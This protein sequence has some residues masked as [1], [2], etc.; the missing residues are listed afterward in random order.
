M[1]SNEF[2]RLFGRLALKLEVVSAD[3]LR[4]AED[5]V[6]KRDGTELAAV[7]VEQGAMTIEQHDHVRAK[8]EALVARH[9]GDL[10]AALTSLDSDDDPTGTDAG[11]K[12][13]E[14]TVDTKPPE[15]GTAPRDRAD[16][17]TACFE[18]TIITPG[19]GDGIE[20]EV[21]AHLAETVDRD[22]GGAFGATFI[23]PVDPNFSERLD[24]RD[25]ES[26]LRSRYTLTRVC[27]VGGI[28]EVWLAKDPSLKRDV[29]LKRFRADREVDED[30]KRR[31]V[32][33][34]QITGQLEHPNIVPVH[35]LD[36]ME[37]GSPYYTMKLLR[38]QTLSQHIQE[39]HKLKRDGQ[40]SMLSLYELLNIFV[41]VCNAVA[42][43]GAR[44]I[45]HRDLKPANIM[46]GG[47]G[48]VLVLDWG[49]A[50]LVDRSETDEEMEPVT[51]Q[52]NLD[53]VQ[54][55]EGQIVGTP[56]YMAPEQAAGR[57]GQIDQRTDVYGLGAVLYAILLGKTPHRGQQTG[58][59]ARDTI[60]LLKRIVDGPTPRPRTV[61]PTI[62][63][64]LDA[65]SAKAME[66]SRSDRYQTAT[67]IAQDIK[68]WM[69][70]EP[71]SAYTEPWTD[72][73]Q[74]WFRKHRTLAQSIVIGVVLT[75]VVSIFAAFM[76]N[77]A[78]K[79]EANAHAETAAARLVALDHFQRT[80][81][82][83]DELLTGLSDGLLN[84]PETQDF[85]EELLAYAEE[86]YAKLVAETS[87]DAALQYEL[88]QVYIRLGDVRRLLNDDSAEES[89]LEAI[90]RL[91]ATDGQTL[92]VARVNNKLGLWYTADGRHD[93]AAERFELVLDAL[94]ETAPQ[95]GDDFESA[96]I[97]AAALSNRGNLFSRTAHSEEAKQSL[98]QSESD[99]R[100]IV[101]QTRE[102]NDRFALA[103]SRMVLGEHHQQTGKLAESIEKLEQAISDFAALVAMDED[104][105][106]Y[107]QGLADGYLTLS[108]AQYLLGQTEKQIESSRAAIR[109]YD[110]LIATRPDVPVY[111]EN[112]TA[113]ATDLAQALYFKGR[114]SDAFEAARSSLHDASL[115]A[116]SYPHIPRYT[117]SRVYALMTLAQIVRDFGNFEDATGDMQDA[118]D[119]CTAL[120]ELWPNESG[121]FRLRGVCLSNLGTIGLLTDQV[122]SAR[123]LFEQARAD[124]AAALKLAPDAHLARDGLAWALTY[125][126]DA[127]HRLDRTGEASA[128][129]KAAI[130][131]RGEAIDKSPNELANE[132]WL[133]L[134]CRDVELRNATQALASAE[135]AINDAPTN[136]WYQSLIAAAHYR[137][138]DYALC[139]KVLATARTPNISRK[140]SL[141]FWEAM[142]LWQTGD[143][144]KAQAAFEKAVLRMNE[145]APGDLKLRMVRDEAAALLGIEVE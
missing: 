82:M 92:E 96:R 19:H 21:T 137:N 81:K 87:D 90:K 26:A 143:E 44:G 101:E 25:I 4:K 35:E 27:G 13:L 93:D 73:A 65:I 104:E 135:L 128:A 107:V 63:A 24:R 77:E 37:D 74:R 40:D 114:M 52:S 38:G 127:L 32:K 120:I 145:T 78:R 36:Q 124:F 103:Q 95:N 134:T 46:L 8:L 16:E 117:V 12:I 70:D 85:R 88:T 10:A 138:G 69:A 142:A 119:L 110:A 23:S 14:E 7:L 129:Y 49:L 17:N 106:S 64:A 71:V 126:G 3:Q 102:L 139:L 99:W 144:V 130:A 43:A 45:V 51:L 66:R 54:T 105:P 33:E 28:G 109:E 57:I 22:N 67:E 133:L 112:R 140:N 9:K 31:L 115:L 39:H 123:Q 29:A 2:D 5:T 108:A 89:Y 56:A 47:F 68:R 11:S 59:T 48:E 97:R 111:R 83:V 58:N 136:D 86:E 91:N 132:A 98:E 55:L 72:R 1:S 75:A 116:D 60:T 41:D 20:S 61:D 118:I 76:I 125:L 30:T 6:T 15:P 53:P 122:E 121:Y 141:G 18:L 131:L 79:R 113:A 84:L 42:Y 100:Q 80:R 94:K 50:T 34:A 62:P